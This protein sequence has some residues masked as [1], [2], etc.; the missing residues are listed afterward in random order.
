M[1]TASPRGMSQPGAQGRLMTEVA[2]KQQIMNPRI[3]PVKLSQNLLAG[4]GAAVIDEDEF[5]LI[6]KRITDRDQLLMQLGK[7]C[8]LVERRDHNGYPWQLRHDPGFLPSRPP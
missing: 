8:G 7:A 4:V 6:G 3:G 2:R 1:I 5:K